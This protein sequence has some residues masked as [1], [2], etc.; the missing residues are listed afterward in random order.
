MFRCMYLQ[1]YSTDYGITDPL[2]QVGEILE[3]VNGKHILLVNGYPYYKKNLMR[4][5]LTR[6]CCRKASC[7]VYLHVDDGLRAVH[8]GN[9][10]HNHPPKKFCR[11]VTGKYKRVWNDLVVERSGWR[12]YLVGP[13]I[14]VPQAMTNGYKMPVLYRM[15]VYDLS[16]SHNWCVGIVKFI[17]LL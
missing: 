3:M 9:F 17:F 1:S 11:T 12:K 2:G 16:L 4:S 7:N 13:W 10:P 6:F 5:G 14:M 8:S 15:N